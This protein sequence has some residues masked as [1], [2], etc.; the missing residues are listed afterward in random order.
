[1]V[2]LD[3]GDRM[4]D[5]DSHV[6]KTKQLYIT[7]PYKY[8]GDAFVYDYYK[9]GLAEGLDFDDLQESFEQRLKIDQSFLLAASSMGYITIK[10]KT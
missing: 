7:L 8:P 3:I 9:T 4:P 5:V 10:L 1:M 6:L 2:I